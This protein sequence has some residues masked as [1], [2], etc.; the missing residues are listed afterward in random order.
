MERLDLTSKRNLTKT[1]VHDLFQLGFIN[2]PRNVI[3]L[4]PTGVGKT[5]LATALGNQA[6]RKGYS[7]FFIGMNM[8]IEKLAISRAEGGFLKLRDK[9][10]KVDLLILDDL[11]IKRLPPSAVQ[12]LYDIMEERYQSKSTVITTQLP[13][14]NW[15]EVIE[16]LVALEAIVDRIIH[17]SIVINLKGESYRKIRANNLQA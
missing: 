10:T 8:L 17:G 6:C 4:G 11:G 14:E 13:V 7:S 15:K 9:L 2:A 12:D 1:Q 3:I 16:D 5:Y